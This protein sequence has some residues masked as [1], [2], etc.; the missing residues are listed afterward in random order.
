MIFGRDIQLRKRDKRSIDKKF[1]DQSDSIG[2]CID[3]EV[4]FF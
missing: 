1:T 3:R 4:E 2:H